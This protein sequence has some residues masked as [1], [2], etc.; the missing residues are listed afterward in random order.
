[1]NDLGVEGGRH[2]QERADTAGDALELARGVRA[3]RAV[4]QVAAHAL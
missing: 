1:V 3:R 4:V 2:R